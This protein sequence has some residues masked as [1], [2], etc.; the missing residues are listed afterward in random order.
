MNN[1][2]H[3]KEVVKRWGEMVRSCGDAG[4]GGDEGK[5]LLLLWRLLCA[6][7]E[8]TGDKDYGEG[9]GMPCGVERWREWTSTVGSELAH[10]LNILLS[11]KKL[12]KPK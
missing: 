7:M 6:L 11:N 10:P 1:G 5:R 4:G 3:K 2:G 8:R 12:Q 9:R